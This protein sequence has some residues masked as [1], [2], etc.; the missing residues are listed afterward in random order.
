VQLALDRQDEKEQYLF[1]GSRLTFTS[2][3][4]LDVKPASRKGETELPEKSAF[5]QVR[6]KLPKTPFPRN[7]RNHLSEK[8]TYRPKVGRN[9]RTIG[10]VPQWN[11]VSRQILEPSFL[12]HNPSATSYGSG[13]DGGSSSRPTPQLLFGRSP[14]LNSRVP[15]LSE[16]LSGSHVFE[17]GFPFTF[18]CA[19]PKFHP[20]VVCHKF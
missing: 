16:K 2:P 12:C 5:R 9:S 3:V 10:I 19:S 8:A 17:L 14:K 13:K 7:Y 15:P 20:G 6:S 18:T 1:L 4:H 11:K